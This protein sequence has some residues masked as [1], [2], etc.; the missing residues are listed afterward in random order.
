MIINDLFKNKIVTNQQDVAEGSLNELSSDLL[1]RSAQVAK[2]K[3]NQAMDPKIHDALGGGYMN[4]LAKHYNTVADKFS[5]KAAKVGQKDAVKNIASPAVMRK[6]GMAETF[7]LSNKKRLGTRHDRFK[8][9]RVSEDQVPSEVTYRGEI[10]PTADIEVLGVDHNAKTFNITYNKKPYTVKTSLL[11]QEDFD[12]WQ[13]ADYEVEIIN[14]NG[15]DLIDMIDW[16]NEGD[17]KTD[18]QIR[19]I[20]TIIAY[21]DTQRTSDIQYMA[22][23]EMADD[24]EAAELYNEIKNFYNE[25]QQKINRA[26]QWLSKNIQDADVR[27]EFATFLQKLAATQDARKTQKAVEYLMYVAFSYSRE[28][29]TE[30]TPGMKLPGIRLTDPDDED[31]LAQKMDALFKKVEFK[32]DAF[33]KKII[34]LGETFGFGIPDLESGLGARSMYWDRP[35]LTSQPAKTAST[36]ATN[37]L[38]F[39]IAIDKYVQS[40]SSS[41]IKIGLPGIT[42]HSTWEGVLSDKL[43]NQQEDYFATP[44]GFANIAN[45]KIDVSKMID[46]NIQK[47]GVKEG[48]V[49][50]L[51]GAWEKIKDFDNPARQ[52]SNQELRKKQ[53][54]RRKEIKNQDMSE[55]N[56][57]EQDLAE[58]VSTL[59]L[60]DI[61]FKGLEQKFPKII[62]RYGH[63]VVGNAIMDVA[64][65]N[66]DVDSFSEIDMLIDDIIEK[67]QNYN[68]NDSGLTESIV[69]RLYY[70]VVG[71]SA[72]ELRKDFGMR[73]D[74]RGWFLSE[75][76]GRNR[77]MDAQRAFGSPKL[78][79]YS[80]SDATGGAATLGPDNVVSPVGSVPKS[81]RINTKK[82]KK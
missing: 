24:E 59:E 60:A 21:L 41:L 48:I 58:A 63:E 20:D 76:S 30:V 65:E 62:E 45:G 44:E 66:L 3:S 49:D 31:E 51:K 81:Q 50:T 69:S 54:L 5:N 9:L 46:D 22:W 37:I 61:L 25:D 6:I 70:N 11:S 35:I 36:T 34:E 73:H 74:R 18:R 15:K 42:E 55:E 23:K 10:D 27:Q 47:Q 14:S 4:P 38:K 72:P 32:F 28:G 71:T 57:T 53:Q 67:L 12:H 8:S 79:E 52:Q 82:T 75:S 1:Q 40:F 26:T 16:N 33:E 77:I 13:I 78:V 80:I 19:M 43:T 39:K 29:N 56:L 64:E 2:N 68:G 7:R 17:A